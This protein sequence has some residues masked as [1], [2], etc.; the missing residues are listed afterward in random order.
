MDEMMNYFS[1]GPRIFLVESDF[2]VATDLM[3]EIEKEGMVVAC[4]SSSL[5]NGLKQT[6]YGAFDFALLNI[7]L[8]DNNCYPIAKKLIALDIPFAFFTGVNHSEIDVEFQRIPRIAKP[9][10]CRYVAREIKSMITA[11]ARPGVEVAGLS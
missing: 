5:E 6:E 8:R 3:V 7:R 10:D 11:L 1:K 4:V 9:Q 2:L